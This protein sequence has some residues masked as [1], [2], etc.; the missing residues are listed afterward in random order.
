V[1]FK[2]SQH[3]RQELKRRNIPEELV[4][5]VLHNPQ[6]IVPQSQGKKVYQSKMALGGGNFFLLRAIV[7]DEVDPAVVVTVYRTKKISKYWRLA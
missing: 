1:R 3:A 7:V 6:Q 5:S 4:E 2:F